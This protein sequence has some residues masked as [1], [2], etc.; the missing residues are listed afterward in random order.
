MSE[1]LSKEIIDI[2]NEKDTR[3]VLATID[4]NGIPHVVFKGSIHVNDAQNLVLYEILESSATNR[5]LV[6]SIWFDKLVAVNILSKDGI[7]YEIIGKPVRSITAGQ[8]FE[9]TYVA[10]R[11]KL[12]DV[13][14][15]AI[16]V[17]EPIAVRDEN[18]R[19]RFLKQEE[20]YPILKHLDRVK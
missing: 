7:S 3:K 11:E 8:E 4:K 15:A 9:Q 17:I 2:I 18:L 16:W 13:E 1:I 10:V 14:L 12:G 5:N 19:S 20:E 6:Y